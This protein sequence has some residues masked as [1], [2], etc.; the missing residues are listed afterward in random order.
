MSIRR[1]LNL[2]WLRSFE[3]A[4]RLL[5]FTQASQ[6]LGLT[7][8]AVSQHIKAL[9]AQIGES[10]FVR[11]PKSLLLTDAGKAYQG[12]VREAL[13]SIDMSTT[14]LFGPRQVG[15][16]VVRASMAFIVWLAPRL[17]AFQQAH[18]EIGVKLV[19]S[20]W[21]D[22]SDQYPVDVDVVLAQQDAAAPDL[23]KLAD[24]YLVPILG[25]GSCSEIAMPA[26]LARVTPIHVLGYDDHWTRYLAAQAVSVDIRAARLMTDTSVAAIEMVAAGLGGAVIIERFARHAIASGRA[27]R[28]VGDP[29]P[30]GR[31][32][33]L[34]RVNSRIENQISA[35]IFKKWLRSQL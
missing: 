30:L 35:E 26:D 8:A 4:A 24:E 27:I 9:E 16:I 13:A 25:A 3:A 28:V 10:L 31:S 6:E 34:V 7:Q 5:S 15:A 20:L 32:H 21:R 2:N 18:P 19:T 23:E 33:Y 22:S 29:I 11:R 12:P 1:N 17:G 14:G